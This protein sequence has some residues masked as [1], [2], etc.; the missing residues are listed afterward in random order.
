M[1]DLTIGG[2]LEAQYWMYADNADKPLTGRFVSI[3]QNNP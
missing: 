1:M 2:K 3:Q